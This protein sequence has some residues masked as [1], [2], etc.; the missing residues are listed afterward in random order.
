MLL[1]IRNGLAALA[2]ALGACPGICAIAP[3]LSSP[4]FTDGQVEFTLTGESNV[5]Y[6]IEAS[7]NLQAW[8]PIGTNMEASVSRQVRVPLFEGHSFYRALARTP[9]FNFAIVAWDQV[10]LNGNDIVVDSFDSQDAT[11]STG[12]QYDI[13]KR[14]DR[15]VVAGNTLTTNAVELGNAKIF[16]RIQ[17]ATNGRSRMGP[18]V[19][20]GDLAWHAALNTGIQ[21]GSVS[22][23]LTLAPEQVAV[24]YPEGSAVMPYPG[25]FEGVTYKYILGTDNYWMENLRLINTNKMAVLG[26][27]TVYVSSDLAVTGSA[28]IRIFPGATLRLYVGAPTA[29]LGGNGVVNENS[30]SAFVYYGLPRNT[31]ATIAANGTFAGCIYAPSAD[32]TINA[33]TSLLS[34]SGAIA[35]RN[36][37]VSGHAEIHYD[38]ALQR[39]GPFTW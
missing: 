34:F 8:F 21:P 2:V 19:T 24:P 17:T 33:S 4:A 32:L 39:T 36:V 12:G 37:L 23:D 7:T 13:L 22:D 6:R 31:T 14:G 25:V 26:N 27:A 29:S 10:V 20:V 18:N 15:A 1:W 9:R 38:E 35:A 3:S 11:R 30:S 28:F 16:G 5:A